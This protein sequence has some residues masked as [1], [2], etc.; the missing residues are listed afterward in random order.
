MT[1]TLEDSNGYA[2]VKYIINLH[3][4]KYLMIF[5]N[6]RNFLFNNGC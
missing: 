4:K 1:V 5:V 2:N 3:W 6:I